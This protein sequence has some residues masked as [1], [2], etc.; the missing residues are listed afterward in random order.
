MDGAWVD[1]RMS[2]CVVGD[3]VGGGVGDNV[4]NGV[5]RALLGDGAYHIRWGGTDKA[6]STTC[7]VRASATASVMTSAAAL[8]GRSHVRVCH[9]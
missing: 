9:W 2:R 6:A 4:G 3:G 1:V 7:G 5:A 8:G